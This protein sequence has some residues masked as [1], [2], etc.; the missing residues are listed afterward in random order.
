MRLKRAGH[1]HNVTRRSPTAFEVD[2]VQVVA[3]VAG[4]EASGF[5]GDTSAGRTRV[6]VARASDRVFAQIGERS[7]D[8]TVVSRAAAS[9]ADS[10]LE[11]GLEAPMPG[12][13]TRVTVAIGDS[14]KRGQELIVVEAMKMENALVAPMDGVV[15]SLAVKVG[16]MVGPGPALVVIEAEA[17]AR[18]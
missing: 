10:T 18:S 11:G 15:K 8:F 4:T 16:D 9:V 14:V 17:K 2:G 6:F 3:R 1:V 13:V 5:E 12:R 7:L